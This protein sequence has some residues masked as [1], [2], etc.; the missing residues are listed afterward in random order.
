ML[1]NYLLFCTLLNPFIWAEPSG[2]SRA[3]FSLAKQRKTLVPPFTVASP[4]LRSLFVPECG[5]FHCHSL[6]PALAG[7]SHL[8]LDFTQW[9][10]FQELH[11]HS[12]LFLYGALLTTFT[13]DDK[14]DEQT[15]IV[16][17]EPF[18]YQLGRPPAP[19]FK[20]SVPWHRPMAE[21]KKE[22]RQACPISFG[23]ICSNE[24]VKLK[25]NVF[26]DRDFFLWSCKSNMTEN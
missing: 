20:C 15:G 24:S 16:F 17:A 10:L 26:A 3:E 19:S 18:I 8:A 22:T 23:Y 2:G 5:F 9:T 4:S 6:Q 11:P 13:I 25:S 1:L 12:S 14:N 21:Q 7:K